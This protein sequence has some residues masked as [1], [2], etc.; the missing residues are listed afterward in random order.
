MN[1]KKILSIIFGLIIIWLLIAFAFKYK[2]NS[3]TSTIVPIIKTNKTNK[4]EAITDNKSNRIKSQL[5]K[6]TLPLSNSPKDVAW[7]LFQKYLAYDKIG[8]LKGVKSV[9]YKVASVCENP[10]T[11]IDCKA[12]MNLA[13]L[14]G[15]KLKKEDFVNVWN[16]KKQIILATNFKIQEDANVIGRN[17]A[18]IFFIRD[19]KG[20]KML[21]FSPFK[22]AVSDK[23]T[24]SKKELNYRIINYTEDKD[25][26][27]IA[28]YKEE[29][30]AVKTGEICVKTNPNLRDTNGDGWWDG[31]ETLIN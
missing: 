15:S 19:K 17:R 14:Y 9:V 4:K 22:G 13:Y 10:K 30:L 8:D 25:K 20:L 7:R 2:N 29:C 1:F 23:G 27:G 5:P 21:S 24:A 31:I 26:D 6:Q 3:H 12:R 16:D 18:I 28:D 11:A